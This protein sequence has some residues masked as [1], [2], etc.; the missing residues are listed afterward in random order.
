MFLCVV[1]HISEGKEIIKRKVN[2]VVDNHTVRYHLRYSMECE[3]GKW[4]TH[5]CNLYKEYWLVT[6]EAR[7][8]GE[9]Q[10]VSVSRWSMWSVKCISV[11]YL[12]AC[13]AWL[14]VHAIMLWD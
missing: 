4:F 13:P 5:I 12:A 14:I 8:F 6:E 7:V 1:V 3:V 2:R 11:G 9:V 10:G